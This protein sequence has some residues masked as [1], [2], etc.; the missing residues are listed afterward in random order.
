[1]L[2]PLLLLVLGLALLVAGG[3]WIVRGAVALAD[4]LGVPPLVIGLT[5]VAFGTSAPE[6]V[7]NLI[8]AASDATSVGFGNVIGSNIANVA[9]LLGAISLYKPQ[10]VSRS[11]VVREIPMMTLIAIAALVL[12]A[13]QWFGAAG[14]DQWGPADGVVLLLFFS[15]FL[16]YLISESIAAGNQS[17]DEITPLGWG[18][19]LAYLIGG[20]AALIG[21]GQATVS[22]AVDLAGQLGVPEVIVSLTLVAVGTSLPEL[23]ASLAAARRNQSDLAIGNIVG[24]NIFN[25]GF[26]LGISALAK[27]MDIPAYGLGDL[28]VT[29]ALSAALLPLAATGRQI[30][31]WEGALLLAGYGG[32][33]AWLVVR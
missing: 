31:R 21:G 17:T 18:W 3:E 24:S 30:A 28:L 27:P 10:S 4:R 1:M 6:L 15:V 19:T 7:V 22:G 32:Y 33:V 2:A 12:A 23:A 5:V 25:T 29:V 13:D 20:L 11:V 8:A 9:L 14:P 26:I 16:F